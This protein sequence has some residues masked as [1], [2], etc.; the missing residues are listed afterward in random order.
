M[1]LKILNQN[2]NYILFVL[3]VII[4]YNIIK[5][6]IKY[7][8]HEVTPLPF[9][10]SAINLGSKFWFIG[11][12]L[13]G[14]ISTNAANIYNYIFIKYLYNKELVWMLINVIPFMLVACL[15]IAT[16]VACGR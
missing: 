5:K 14:I 16:L 10:K 13:S 9:Q 8:S 6:L 11:I 4:L 7:F 12:I 2:I 3:F 1:L 15:G